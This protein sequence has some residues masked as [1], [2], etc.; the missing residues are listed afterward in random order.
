ML[1]WDLIKCW[2]A[3]YLLTGVATVSDLY[4]EKTISGNVM[5]SWFHYVKYHHIIIFLE[6]QLQRLVHISY[7]WKHINHTKFSLSQNDTHIWSKKKISPICGHIWEAS[8]LFG[9]NVS[10][11][12]LQMRFRLDKSEK[13]L[14]WWKCTTVTDGYNTTLVHGPKSAS[15]VLLVAQLQWDLLSH[16]VR[17]KGNL[18]HNVPCKHRLVCVFSSPATIGSINESK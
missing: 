6:T 9:T 16:C 17:I 10:Y 11:L 3:H 4:G 13:R 2:S 7:N 18:I 12:I 8:H 15:R 5:V 14:R 1:P